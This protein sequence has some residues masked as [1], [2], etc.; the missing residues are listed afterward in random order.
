MIYTIEDGQEENNADVKLKRPISPRGVFPNFVC[1]K[2]AYGPNTGEVIY[3]QSF[4]DNQPRLEDIEYIPLGE[5]VAKGDEKKL[6]R[7]VEELKR[8]L[9]ELLCQRGYR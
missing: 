5:F 1:S 6:D 2:Y 3:K 4:E 7:E 8:M 9:Q